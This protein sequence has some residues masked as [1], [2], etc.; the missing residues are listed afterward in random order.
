MGKNDEVINSVFNDLN[1]I[2]IEIFLRQNKLEEKINDINE[3]NNSTILSLKVDIL[4]KFKHLENVIK[5]KKVTKNEIIGIKNSFKN[6]ENL[7]KKVKII[8]KNLYIDFDNIKNRLKQYDI[9][10]FELWSTRMI[11]Q[12]LREIQGIKHKL[13]YVNSKISQRQEET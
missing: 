5:Q 4:K 7:S 3:E 12:I 8:Y 11:E 1:N 6:V 9:K 10:D 13:D 2:I